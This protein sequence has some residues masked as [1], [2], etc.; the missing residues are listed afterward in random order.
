[1]LQG[2]IAL[3]S[4]KVREN[5]GLYDATLSLSCELLKAHCDNFTDFAL[6]LGKASQGVTQFRTHVQAMVDGSKLIATG[7]NVDG[8]VRDMLA[9]PECF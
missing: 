5:M 1:M 3:E 4:F 9:L 6:T 7:D 2:V 8:D